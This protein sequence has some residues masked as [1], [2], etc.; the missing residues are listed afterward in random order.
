MAEYPLSPDINN[1]LISARKDGML[2]V[3]LSCIDMMGKRP[4][5]NESKMKLLFEVIKDSIDVSNIPKYLSESTASGG[6]PEKTARKDMKLGYPSH[7]MRI[8]MQ[9]PVPWIE[10][11]KLSRNV[12]YKK[13]AWVVIDA[14]LTADCNKNDPQW[15]DPALAFTMDWVNTF[16]VEGQEEDF[17]WYDMAVG[18]RGTKLAYVLRRALIENEDAD[19]ILR[20]LIA[21]EAH[22][23]ELMKKEKI[24]THSNHG[25]FQMAGLLALGKSLPFLKIANEAVIFST[26]LIRKMLTE[27][28][29]EDGLH[30][31]HSP[32]Y[33]L[34]MTNYISIL[35]NS[36]FMTDS[37]D[38]L[39]LANNALEAASWLCQPDENILPFGDSPPIHIERRANFPIHNVKG[40][41]CAPHGLK[42]FK[43]GGLVIYNNHLSNE[44]PGSYLA[45]NGSFHSRQHKHAD[46]MNIQLFHKGV[47]L[48]TDAGTYTYQYDL[49][50]RIF[51]ESTR[52]HNCLEIDGHNYSRF[53]ADVFGS[54][55]ENVSQ[56]GDCIVIQSFVDRKK[57][58]PH[59]LPNNNIK[60]SN[61]VNINVKHRRIVVYHPDNFL[62]IIDVLK[63]NEKHNYTQWFNLYPEL[64]V[65]TVDSHL[66]LSIDSGKAI[67]TLENIYPNDSEVKVYNAVE[68]PRLQGWICRNGHSLE[69]TNSIG[70]GKDDKN[71]TI[72]TVINL[73]TVGNSRYYFK[74]GTDGK[75][76][77][78]V[79]KRDESEY[80]FIY[81]MKTDATEISYE[82]NGILNESKFGID[83]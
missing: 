61:S 68:K 47:G 39:S 21:C 67:A 11:K 57:I 25:L 28:F 60:T 79:L 76:L 73:N 82:A 14:T 52:A 27:H 23:R 8:H 7:G 80:E 51:I 32:V 81:R 31:E 40:K 77:R 78:F 66:L 13:Q 19:V 17:V 4:R 44:L 50:E 71:S 5:T 34:Y 2:D 36:G 15:Y 38:F 30:K 74:E 70:V 62:L 42:Y 20:L 45:F 9:T 69:R 83:D 41:P 54:A 56:I 35:L 1:F 72:A 6:D 18:Q 3:A 12:R 33:H 63:S 43:T 29:T 48:L 59:D 16:I 10:K 26:E 55:I 75:Y 37:G 46:D 65:T 49:P 24:A 53:M 58:V 22:I 64:E